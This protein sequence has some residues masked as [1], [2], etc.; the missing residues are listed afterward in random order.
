VTSGRDYNLSFGR[1]KEE[2]RITRT[3]KERMS[4]L[5]EI[6]LL[7]I[8]WNRNAEPCALEI[9]FCLISGWNEISQTG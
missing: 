5:V 9:S 1:P 4:Q 8:R 6:N 3:E 7:A 2:E